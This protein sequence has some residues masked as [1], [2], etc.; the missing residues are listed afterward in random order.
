MGALIAG[1]PRQPPDMAKARTGMDQT[2]R[3]LRI[4]GAPRFP[5]GGGPSFT[6]RRLAVPC[7]RSSSAQSVIGTP[8]YLAAAT[9]RR[10]DNYGGRTWKDTG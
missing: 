7:L 10:Q 8:Q 1:A 5:S 9:V 3:A 2:G 6:G 4:E